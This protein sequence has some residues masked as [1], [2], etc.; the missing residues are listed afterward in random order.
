MKVHQ[1]KKNKEEIQR[2]VDIANR[3]AGFAKAASAK[4]PAR[5]TTMEELVDNNKR[6]KRKKNR[7]VLN[8]NG[9][10]G[11]CLGE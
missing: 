3:E 2:V 7:R 1:E 10:F 5:N 4:S 11:K 8:I 9:L 6:P